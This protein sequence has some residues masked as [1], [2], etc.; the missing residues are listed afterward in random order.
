MCFF[1]QDRGAQFFFMFKRSSFLKQS[2][3]LMPLIYRVFVKIS[4]PYILY[5]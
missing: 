4:V 2:V 3:M 1:E 5:Y